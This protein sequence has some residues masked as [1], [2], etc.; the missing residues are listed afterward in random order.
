VRDPDESDDDPGNRQGPDT[1]GRHRGARQDLLGLV[2]NGV[3]RSHTDHAVEVVETGRV[4]PARR[5][6][7][8]VALDGRG[9]EQVELAVESGGERVTAF[10][11]AHARV[12]APRAPRVPE[13]TGLRVRAQN[14]TVDRVTLLA[15]DAR[16]GDRLALAEFVRLTQADVWRFSAHLVD[17]DAADD[18]TQEVYVRA[19]RAL[20]R[21]RG[22]SSARTW[23]LAI[24]RN[25]CADRL[26]RR[27][28]RRNLERRLATE[29]P[30]HARPGDGSVD[31]DLLVAGLDADRRE[32]FVLTQVVGLSYEEAAAACGCPVGTIRSRVAR[33]RRDLLAAIA[34]SAEA[35]A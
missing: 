18:L 15:L 13:V 29:P 11:T 28:R 20:P 4:G 2:G 7:A 25:A 33:A 34:P 16:D 14:A 31:L 6:T 5:T 9:R 3:R 23:L 8:Q 26:R 27:T 17:R 32:A 21:F 22:E 1:T 24:T 30:P 12:V 35:Q 10:L 19:L